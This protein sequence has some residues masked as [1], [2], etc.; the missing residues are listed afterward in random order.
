LFALAQTLIQK[1]SAKLTHIPREE[2][3]HADCMANESLD[4]KKPMPVSFV[5][6]LRSHEITI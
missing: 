6:F 1:M 4:A 2:N 3:E 5:T